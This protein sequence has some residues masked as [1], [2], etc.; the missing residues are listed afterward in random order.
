MQMPSISKRKRQRN[1]GREIGREEGDR[2]RERRQEEV[3]NYQEVLAR[4]RCTCTP[5]SLQLTHV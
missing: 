4:Q 2:G 3:I 1:G 5:A